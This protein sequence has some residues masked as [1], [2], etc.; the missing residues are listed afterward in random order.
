MFTPHS[1]VGDILDRHPVTEK[2]LTQLGFTDLL[3][4]I[5]RRT[6][7]KFATLEMAAAKKNIAVDELIAI[8]EKA[9]AQEDS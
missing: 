6:V 9:I 7:A 5:M 4:P 2:V 8:L 3:N 1:K